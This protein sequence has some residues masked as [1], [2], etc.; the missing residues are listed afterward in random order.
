MPKKK[1]DLSPP[2]VSTLG[3]ATIHVI[4]DN[5][6]GVEVEM[7][8]KEWDSSQHAKI[9]IKDVKDAAGALK[10][11]ETL[12]FKAGQNRYEW[13]A[14]KQ[15]QTDA[16]L[17]FADAMQALKNGTIKQPNGCATC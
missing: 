10:E 11:G 2:T 4:K 3:K 17:T 14:Y 9:T 5:L 13:V 6:T 8:G 1:L 7:G 15:I 16:R 12:A